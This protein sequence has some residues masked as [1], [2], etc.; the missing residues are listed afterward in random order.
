MHEYVR[1]YAF[2]QSRNWLHGCTVS[3]NKLN[4]SSLSLSLSFVQ[5]YD[6]PTE[7][8]QL[9]VSDV[10]NKTFTFYTQLLEKKKTKNKRLDSK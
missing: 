1:Q 3:P 5:N 7:R 6:N 2:I 4:V 8:L 9:Y 10:P